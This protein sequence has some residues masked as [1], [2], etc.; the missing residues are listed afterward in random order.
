ME[1]LK[2]FFFLKNQKMK[3]MMLKN[4]SIKKIIFFFF[5]FF[6]SLCECLLMN[7]KLFGVFRKKEKN[8]NFINKKF[9]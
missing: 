3:K 9:Y 1:K 8:G 5:N 4:A 7:E 2:K 6:E